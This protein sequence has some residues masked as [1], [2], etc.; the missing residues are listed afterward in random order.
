MLY[1]GPMRQAADVMRTATGDTMNYPTMDDTGNVGEQ[2]AEAGSYDRV[3]V[4]DE[5]DHR[6]RFSSWRTSSARSLIRLS[7]N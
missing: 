2:L 6:C 5:S 1:F 4:V 3:S 7:R